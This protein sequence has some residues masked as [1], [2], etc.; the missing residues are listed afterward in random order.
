MSID[1][2]KL[3]EDLSKMRGILKEYTII[4][5]AS[6]GIDSEEQKELDQMQ[7]KIDLLEGKIQE[8]LG[9]ST[10]DTKDPAVVSFENKWMNFIQELEG[11]II[12]YGL[13]VPQQ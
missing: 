3:Q 10:I 11:D 1:L 6:D 7:G 4:F 12:K 5:E 9:D 8:L 2:I 13:D